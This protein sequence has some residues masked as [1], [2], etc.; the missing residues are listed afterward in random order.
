MK[1]SSRSVRRAF[2]SVTA[3]IAALVLAAPAQSKPDVSL[4][5]SIEVLTEF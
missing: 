5:F 1:S 4:D 3:A 2:A